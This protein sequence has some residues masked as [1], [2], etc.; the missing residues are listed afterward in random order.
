[1]YVVDGLEE[2]GVRAFVDF[3]VYEGLVSMRCRS[4]PEVS[5][6]RRRV[7]VDGLDSSCEVPG[8]LMV[9]DSNGWSV[10]SRSW[11]WKLEA[12][13]LSSGNVGTAGVVFFGLKKY[14]LALDCR[15][16]G[17]SN[18]SARCSEMADEVRF[19]TVMVEA[20]SNNS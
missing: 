11:F 12:W 4:C 15:V 14:P 8:T 9:Y 16:F 17:S 20:I 2:S 13:P 1:L 19:R 6:V 3:C 5:S 7:E 10:M 18:R